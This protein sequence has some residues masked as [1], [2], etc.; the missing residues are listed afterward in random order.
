MIRRYRLICQVFLDHLSK[1]T[2]KEEEPKPVR[3]HKESWLSHQDG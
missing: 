3:R 2:E 1:R